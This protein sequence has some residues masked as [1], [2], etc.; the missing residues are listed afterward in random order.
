M[1]DSE[2]PSRFFDDPAAPAG[3]RA[4]FQQA[5]ADLGTD[6][7][8]ARLSAR[9]GP[10]LGAPVAPGPAASPSG[11]GLTSAAKA[12]LA[13]LALIVAGGSAWLLSTSHVEVSPAPSAGKPSAPLAQVTTSPAAPAVVPEGPA[14]SFSAAPPELAPSVTAEAPAKPVIAQPVS[15][16]ELLEQARS[17]LKSDPA[18]ALARANEHARRF[19]RGVLVQEREVIAIKALRQLGRAADAD[20]RAD[21]FSKA[22]PGSAFQRKL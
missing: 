4:A 12:G 17:A 22:F 11:A 21:A 16:A 7:Q 1:N 18:R 20:K 10:M 13:S 15:E 9:L 8:L 2:D 14:P 5:R 6:A 19:P 3:L